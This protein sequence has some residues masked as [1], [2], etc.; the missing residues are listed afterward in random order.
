MWSRHGD[1]EDF[2]KAKAASYFNLVLAAEDL[3]ES[4]ISEG[5]GIYDGLRTPT[6]GFLV[7]PYMWKGIGTLFDFVL[8]R[9]KDS[10]QELTTTHLGHGILD[11]EIMLENCA[12]MYRDIAVCTAGLLEVRKETNHPRYAGKKVRPVVHPHLEANPD[13]VVKFYPQNSPGFFLKVFEGQKIL[14]C[15]GTDKREYRFRLVVAAVAR[16]RSFEPPARHPHFV[17]V[18]GCASD[19]INVTRDP[20]LEILKPQQ[21]DLLCAIERLYGLG[22]LGWRDYDRIHTGSNPETSLPASHICTWSCRLH[23]YFGRPDFNALCMMWDGNLAIRAADCSGGHPKGYARLRGVYHN[24]LLPL[25]VHMVDRGPQFQALVRSSTVWPPQKR[26]CTYYRGRC[27]VLMPGTALEATSIAARY[28]RKWKYSI[29]VDYNRDILVREIPVF[30]DFLSQ[31]ASL[32]EHSTVMFSPG[33]H[34]HWPSDSL[35]DFVNFG[36]DKPCLYFE[37]TLEWWLGRFIPFHQ[38]YRYWQEP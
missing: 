19:I 29:E 22:Q 5:L 13:F 35:Y 26:I 3:H 1:D 36:F 18:I 17:P 24:L 38:G 2:Y 31:G 21:A 20:K 8:A 34:V 10:V 7:E 9:N 12:Q 23:Y 4:V 28:F 25:L 32:V 15:D 30:Q 16:C 14:A 11:F 37:V 33:D 27:S 6:F